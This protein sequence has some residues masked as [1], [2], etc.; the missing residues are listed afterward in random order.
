VNKVIALAFGISAVAAN[1]ANA[2]QV[3]VVNPSAGTS[4]IP[5]RILAP[6]PS[7][8]SSSAVTSSTPVST[9]S[10]AP[11]VEPT[12]VPPATVEG[13]PPALTVTADSVTSGIAETGIAPAPTQELATSAPTAGTPAQSPSIVQQVLSSFGASVQPAGSSAAPASSEGASSGGDA[14]PAGAAPAAPTTVSQFTPQISAAV[15]SVNVATFTPAQ[16]ST[17]ISTIDVQ[18]AQ[19]GLAPAAR[20][21]LVTERARLAGIAQQ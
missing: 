6:A 11:S 13:L 4:N 12:S 16:V 10:V 8:T 17:L 5:T 18:L 3:S 21:V 14:A 19:P 9:S 2:G 15:Q 20:Q 1:A 7:S